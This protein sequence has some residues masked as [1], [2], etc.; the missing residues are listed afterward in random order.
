MERSPHQEELLGAAQALVVDAACADAVSAL[1]AAGVRCLLLRGPA[2]AALL[3][4][5]PAHRP[6]ADVD[7]LV[8]PDRLPEAEAALEA[9]GLTESALEAAFPEG[10]PQHAHTWHTR[11]GGMVDLHR[12]LLGIGAPAPT[13][14]H[15]LSRDSERITVQT[16]EAEIPSVAARA[17]IVALHAAHHVDDSGTA[18]ND[19]ERAL[20]RLAPAAWLEAA[21]L[22]RELDAVGAFVAG[23]SLS[24]RGQ[25]RL[26]QLGLPMRPT[27]LTSVGRGESSFHVAQG[28]AW[29][30]NTPGTRAKARFLR[31]RLLPSPRTMRR[32]SRLARHGP[33]GLVLAYLARLLDAARH[34]PTAFRALRR[35]RR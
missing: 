2:L 21:A 16:V 30:G 24:P 31:R 17:L 6:Y 23:L 29:L 28:I 1:A 15:L 12:A 32:R 3:Y 35:I 9:L 7:L 25:A 18:L 34:L 5:A 20:A 8:E 33:A 4:D 11:L 22:A 26:R 19:L 10:R 13:A 14:W 27:G